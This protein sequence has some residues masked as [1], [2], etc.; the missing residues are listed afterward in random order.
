M[1]TFLSVGCGI[2]LE[3]TI[4]MISGCLHRW[5]RTE[6]LEKIAFVFIGVF[7]VSVFFRPVIFSNR[8]FFFR[9][10]HRYFYPMKFFL[11][12]ALQAGTL[13]FWC[14]FY[15]CGAPFVSDIQSGVFYPV[16]VLFTLSAFPKS[17]NAYILLHFLL[18]FCFFYLFIRSLRLS[19]HTAVLTAIS[20]SF[21]GYMIASVNTLNNLST[22]I[23]LPAVLWAFTLHC[24]DK[25]RTGLLMVTLFLCFG[26]VGGEPQLAMLTCGVLILYAVVL[27]DSAKDRLKNIGTALA[28]IGISL[29]MSMIQLGPTFLDFRHSIRSGGIPYADATRHS[30]NWAMLKHL[31]VP[32]I[33]PADFAA[34][35]GIYRH[36]FP[37]K[38]GIPWLMTIYPGMVIVPLAVV[39]L[40]GAGAGKKVFWTL[41]F[42]G[43]LLLSL[44]R[45]TP[46]YGLF[47]RC[48]PFFRFPEKFM[49]LAGLS[50]LVLAAYGYE[51]ILQRHSVRHSR[52]GRLVVLLPALLFADLYLAHRHLNP[53]CD[54]GFYQ[55]M[56]PN[57]DALTEDSEPFRI[58]V[59]P[60]I[61]SDA[62]VNTIRK[63]HIYWQEMIMPNLGVLSGLHHVGGKTGLVLDYQYLITELLEKNWMKR[64]RFLRLS[65]VKY[66]LSSRPLER[67]PGLKDQIYRIRP[68]LYRLTGHLPRAFLIG[69]VHPFGATGIDQ[70][71]DGRFDPRQSAAGPKSLADTYQR[72]YF[73]AVDQIHYRS[74]HQIEIEATVEKPSVLIL[75]EAFYPGWR[76]CVDGREK[77]L[78]PMNL[79]FQGVELDAGF[80]RIEF[81]YCPP[82]FTGYAAVS[83]AACTI[84][85]GIWIYSNVCS[86]R[87]TPNV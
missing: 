52:V 5:K 23:W 59:D 79:L 74:N 61:G 31:L 18:G 30:M 85:A 71:I 14:P 54:A 73:K 40:A 68:H 35:P 51:A 11:A 42:A 87:K 70:I 3:T 20:Y 17:L 19:K 62:G 66:I 29:A 7:G 27:G 82:Y 10:I 49:F 58:Y 34:D 83:I 75:S 38:D 77:P 41:V 72:T 60:E 33:F 84:F 39:G 2:R 21:G 76:V 9:D 80:H 50:L 65:N 53:T 13:P 44:G 81:A 69:R 1:P 67:L 57:L 64:I 37:G 6:R 24:H 12:E 15:F 78:L 22:Q 48:F 25:N 47:Y 56:D 8:T 45:H 28:V 26:I 4:P 43:S 63:T 36:F 46:L 16:S 86:R 55:Y 32:L